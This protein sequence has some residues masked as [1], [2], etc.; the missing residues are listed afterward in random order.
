[1]DTTTTNDT[2]ADNGRVGS[3]DWFG[4]SEWLAQLTRCQNGE[5]TCMRTLQIIE[6]ETVSMGWVHKQHAAMLALC[7]AIERMP[8]SDQQ[9]ALS[10]QASALAQEMQRVINY[11]Y[12]EAKRPNAEVSDGGHK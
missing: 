6:R 1:M 10:I 3:G 9:T 7:H 4:P 12:A 2:T 11:V 5:T 8:A